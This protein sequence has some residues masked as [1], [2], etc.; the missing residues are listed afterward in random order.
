MVDPI[1]RKAYLHDWKRRDDGRHPG[2]DYGFCEFAKDAA[3]W[4]M[5]ELAQL[6]CDHVFNGKITIPSLTGAIHVLDNFAVEE[7]G[8]R[9]VVFCSGPFIYRERGVSNETTDE[10]AGR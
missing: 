6:D 3:Y 1:H 4:P 2:M 5:R 10:S 7:F 8:D 9:F